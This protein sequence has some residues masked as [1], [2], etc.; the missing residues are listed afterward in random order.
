VR[1]LQ[2]TAEMIG[3]ERSVLLC[4]TDNPI[5][6]GSTWITGPVSWFRVLVEQVDAL[7]ESAEWL[8]GANKDGEDAGEGVLL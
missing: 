8:A 3:A 4:R 2:K 1:R 5:A 6:H 7:L